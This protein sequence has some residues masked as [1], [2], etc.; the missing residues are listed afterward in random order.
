MGSTNNAFSKKLPRFTLIFSLITGLI[1]AL[2]LGLQLNT[3][4]TA[5]QNHLAKALSSQLAKVVRDPM[6][7]QDALSLQVEVDEML[8]IEGVQYAA[9]QD[10]NH[11]LLVQAES[12]QTKTSEHKASP[13]ISPITIENTVAGYAVIKLDKTFFN[14][15]FQHLQ[16]TFIFLWVVITSVLLFLS[17][18]QGK[19]ISNRLQQ[20]LQQLPGN[21]PAGIDELGCLERRL[22]PLL[23]NREPALSD[24]EHQHCT[25]L[26]VTCKNLLKLETQV[27]QEHF[28]SVMSQLDCLIDATADLYGAQ[29]LSATQNTANQSHVSE[30]NIYLK[31]SGESDQNDHPRRALYCAIIIRELS[32]Q[33]LNKQGVK[34]ELAVAITQFEQQLTLSQLLNERVLH[35]QINRLLSFLATANNGDIL[36]DNDTQEHHSLQGVKLSPIADTP[37]N[38]HHLYRADKVNDGDDALITQQLTMLS[39]KLQLN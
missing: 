13:H 27:N 30:N 25:L 17:I 14:A 39:Q 19:N 38:N 22:E 20:L 16:M 6:I 3:I 15:P 12:Q 8:S 11:Q 9:V 7:Q 33:L 36:M 10:A 18:Y 37:S 28:E 34:L 31:F 5:Q 21:N 26:A 23:A 4:T 32:K 29:R 1:I 2:I 35:E 24:S